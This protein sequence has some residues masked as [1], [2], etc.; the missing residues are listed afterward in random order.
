MKPANNG[1]PVPENAFRPA[2]DY[3]ATVDVFS[4]VPQQSAQYYQQ[5]QNERAWVMPNDAAMMPPNAEPTEYVP[6]TEAYG[7]YAPNDG[8]YNG[9]APNNAMCYSEP[10]MPYRNSAM[11]NELPYGKPPKKNRKKLIIVLASAAVLILAAIL[12]L[13]LGL[14]EK[15]L[16]AE[17]EI[18]SSKY[19]NG[20]WQGDGPTLEIDSKGRLASTF[21]SYENYDST[22]TY[23]YNED[24]LVTYIREKNVMEGKT[25]YV[26][27][28]ENTYDG[29]LLVEKC[30]TNQWDSDV[31]VETVYYTYDSEGLLIRETH[32]D[33]GTIYVC[34]LTYDES[35]KLIREDT[36]EKSN[37]SLYYYDSEGRLTKEEYYYEGQFG[38][39]YEYSYDSQGRLVEKLQSS[40]DTCNSCYV[41]YEYNDKGLLV[42]VR[43]TDMWSDD[44]YSMEFD[45]GI[46]MEVYELIKYDIE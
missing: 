8:T 28:V 25:S 14:F 5:Y 7:E 11:S 45:R 2:E 6:N 46:S 27:T 20:D 36:R 29:D 18:A 17:G 24:G 35:G 40:V 30:I 23:E 21:A 1:N 16:V 19:L 38:G 3:D 22:A 33:D 39:M 44:E 9:Y 4:G 12:A 41:R 26:G 43:Y 32:D 37:Y 31:F 34:Y 15:P 13:Y 10:A 42:A